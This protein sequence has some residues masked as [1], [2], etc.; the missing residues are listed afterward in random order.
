MHSPPPSFSV[1]HSFQENSKSFYD[2][3]DDSSLKWNISKIKGVLI[4][5]IEKYALLE[6]ILYLL[7]ALS[8]SS[9]TGIDLLCK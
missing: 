6:A 7:R 8:D 4:I 5:I 1:S 3:L 9:T 2:H